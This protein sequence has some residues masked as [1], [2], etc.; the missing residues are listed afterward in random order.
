MSLASVL[1]I[2]KTVTFDSLSRALEIIKA[3]MVNT[4]MFWILTPLVISMLLMS[5]YFGRYK[6]EELGWNTA[7]GNSIVLVFACIDLVRH[8]YNLGLLFQF[9]AQNALI[10]VLILE[11]LF[12]MLFN[13]FHLL[14]KSFAFGLS[15]GLTINVVV[16]FV[17]VLVYSKL[18]MDYITAIAAVL[19]AAVLVM[20]ISII[21]MLLPEASE[22]EEAGIV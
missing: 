8:T 21:Q 11:G 3:P 13:F 1:A 2:A 12:L 9:N 16:L 17:I 15:S 10:A 19:L 22:E 20:I 6:K 4:E 7:F 14:P 5:F 18:P